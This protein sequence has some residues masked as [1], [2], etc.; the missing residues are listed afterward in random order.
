KLERQWQRFLRHLGNPLALFR[1]LVL[2]LA[3]DFV[4]FLS[5]TGTGFGQLL[6]PLQFL[7]VRRGVT[8][9]PLEL[10]FPR[11]LPLTQIET[12][13]SEEKTQKPATAP[14]A[15][16]KLLSD[17][18]I[19]QEVIAVKK[20]VPPPQRKVAE[21]ELSPEEAMARRILL[22]L[23]AGPSD[24]LENLAARHLLKEPLFLRSI[25][26]Y[27]GT[28]FI[29]TEKAVWERMAA[30]ERRI[31]EYCIRES[32]RKNLPETRFVLLKE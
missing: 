1:F 16:E 21:Q 9:M 15:V 3:L 8:L 11:S 7:S 28:L 31:T 12:A 20:L 23:I 14:P 25:W 22:E 24:R 32:L 6:N 5:L 30:N 27:E 13:Y 19:A 29:S 17:A 10:Y 2:L 26:S 18:E 4:A